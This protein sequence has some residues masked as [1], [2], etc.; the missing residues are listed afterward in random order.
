MG[1]V[2]AV[3]FRSKTDAKKREEEL[4]QLAKAVMGLLDDPAWNLIYESSLGFVPDKEPA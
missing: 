3:D 1:E 2:I 4:E